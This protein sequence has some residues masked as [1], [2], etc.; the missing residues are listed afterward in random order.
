MDLDSDA[1]IGQRAREAA[2]RY[3]TDPTY[4]GG[5]DVP[6]GPC[7]RCGTTVR[8]SGVGRKP[9]WCSQTCRQRAKEARR[10]AREGEQPLSIVDGPAAPHNAEEWVERLLSPQHWQLLAAVFRGM[11]RHIE[12]GWRGGFP[13]DAQRVIEEILG[14]PPATVTRLRDGESLPAVVENRA[15]PPATHDRKRPSDQVGVE[16]VERFI[17]AITDRIAQ[18]GTDTGGT[19]YDRVLMAARRM[20]EAEEAARRADK[21]RAAGR[22]PPAPQAGAMNR[23]QRRRAAR[24]QTGAGSRAVNFDPHMA[25]E[26]RETTGLR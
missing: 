20:V 18:H 12:R 3:L 11:V 4:R 21:V 1:E 13:P 7:P 15:P 24:E 16:D 17:D 19:D 14:L 9:R 22:Y 8:W 5:K 6:L 26:S 23:Q 2:H 25:P 10:V